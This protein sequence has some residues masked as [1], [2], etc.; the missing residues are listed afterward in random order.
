MWRYV[1]LASLVGLVAAGA[2]L[3]PA[4][5][6]RADPVPD[7]VG[8]RQ[9]VQL[10]ADHPLS[11][12]KAGMTQQAVEKILGKPDRLT[13]GGVIGADGTR[14]ATYYLEIPKYPGKQLMTVHYRQ[15]KGAWVFSEWRGPAR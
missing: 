5:P 9:P 11:K 8:E 2:I 7:P 15:D 14:F 13:D 4:P 12:L 3:L 1:I 6:G 10:P